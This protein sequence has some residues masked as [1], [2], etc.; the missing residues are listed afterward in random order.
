MARAI[1]TF[2][3]MPVDILAPST[4]R[5]S[6][7]F[8]RSKMVSIRCPQHVGRQAVEAAEIL[9]HLPGG[10]AVVDGRVG[11]HETDLPADLRRLADHV[12]AVD[13]GRAAGGPQHRAENPQGGRLARAVGAQ[14]PVDLARQ[15][16]EAESVQGHEPPAAEVGVMFCQSGDRNHSFILTPWATGECKAFLWNSI[17]LVLAA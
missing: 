5:I 13:R 17:G 11:R 3:L 9:D 14:Q 10:H 4:S 8:S 16:L 7:I 1:E 12:E 6:F 15:G 2:C